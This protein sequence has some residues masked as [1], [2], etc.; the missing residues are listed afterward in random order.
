MIFIS[1]G[2][3]LRRKHG[4]AIAHAHSLTQM[5]TSP[6][7]CLFQEFLCALLYNILNLGR[8][9]L[10]GRDSGNISEEGFLSLHYILGTIFEKRTLRSK[11]I[12]DSLS[13][14]T[15]SPEFCRFM[16]EKICVYFTEIGQLPLVK[17]GRAICL[18]RYG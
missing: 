5:A 11:K 4:F 16:H 9:E 13:D 17:L 8:G 3:G 2:S 12:F 15:N 1:L 6:A 7:Y 10:P 18:K 14:L